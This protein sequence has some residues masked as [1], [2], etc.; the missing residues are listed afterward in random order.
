[1]ALLAEEEEDIQRERGSELSEMMTVVLNLTHSTVW[2]N[3]PVRPMAAHLPRC[4][5]VVTTP[6]TPCTPFNAFNAFCGYAYVLVGKNKRNQ[7][8]D[9]AWLG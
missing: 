2:A 6:F 3:A 8:T 5:V 9:L 1:M 7:E 4:Q